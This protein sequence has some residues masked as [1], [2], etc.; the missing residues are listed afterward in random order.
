MSVTAFATLHNLSVKKGHNPYALDVYRAG[1]F[2]SI[3]SGC[4]QARDRLHAAGLADTDLFFE[5]GVQR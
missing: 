3:I 2:R 1:S 5:P 4:V